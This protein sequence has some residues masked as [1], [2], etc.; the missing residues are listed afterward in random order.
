MRD[1]PG[2]ALDLLSSQRLRFVHMKLQ[3]SLCILSSYSDIAKGIVAHARG[4]SRLQHM[5]DTEAQ[6][7]SM[8]LR[9][10]MDTVTGHIRRVEGLLKTCDFITQTV[11]AISGL[12]Q[13][14]CTLKN[15]DVPAPGLSRQW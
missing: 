6:L 5:R 10:Q 1:Q 4:L 9:S 7:V 11:G 13:E 12:V 3:R 2:F 15:A 14:D 8:A